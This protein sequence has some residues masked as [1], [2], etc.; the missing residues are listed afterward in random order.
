MPPLKISIW[1][2]LGSILLTIAALHFFHR[3]RN[4]EADRLRDEN[5]RMRFQINQREHERSSTVGPSLPNRGGAKISEQNLVP[6][7]RSVSITAAVPVAGDYRNEGQETPLAVMQ[8]FAWACDR[9]DTAT[10][11]KLLWF[12]GEGREKAKAFMASLPENARGPWTS[13]EAM[14]AAVYVGDALNNPFPS[15]TVLEKA[16]VV[17]LGEDR[18]VLKL[19]GTIRERSEYQKT[20]G[21]WKW[22]IT[23]AVV[24]D[25]VKRS[26]QNNAGR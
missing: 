13:P 25:Y 15:A 7:G 2:A 24:D 3:N 22:V 23:E 11:E 1:A 19:P 18:V 17:Q 8:T 10:M 14:A 4:G 6:S 26:T 21:V 20:E 16:E 5:N 12:E 9:G